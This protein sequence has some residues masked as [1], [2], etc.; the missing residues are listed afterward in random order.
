MNPLPGRFR[1]MLARL[2]VLVPLVLGSVGRA[3][4]EPAIGLADGP[5]GTGVGVILGE[6]TGLSVAWGGEGPSGFDGAL[7]WSVPESR[8]HLHADYLYELVSFRDPAA[9]VVD[10]PVYIG[11]GPRLHLGD[12]PT[13]DSS[14]IGIRMP[15]GLGVQALEVPVEG[16]FE[17]VPVLGLYPR[18]R[19]DFDAALGV[20]V[21]LDT[22]LQ[23]IKRKRPDE[24]PSS[25]WDRI[26]AEEE[27]PS[28]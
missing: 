4:A 14:V 10:F 13:V 28:E 7:A 8:V 16:F 5:R 2:C 20:R 17:L 11:V 22:R 1:P 25:T 23:A 24:E 3:V 19:M 26:E 6:P 27:Q 12:V 9:P 18:T 21:Y 15:V